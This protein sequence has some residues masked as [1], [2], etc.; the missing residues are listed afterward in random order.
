MK[1]NFLEEVKYLSTGELSEKVRPPKKPPV[2]PNVISTKCF[3]SRLFP[4][5]FNY[6]F[7]MEEQNRTN[8]QVI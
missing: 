6:Y 5:R 1:L 3:I 4:V 8:M 2:P 7:Q